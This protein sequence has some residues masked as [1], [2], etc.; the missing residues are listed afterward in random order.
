[1]F[2]DRHYAFF[3]TLNLFLQHYIIRGIG[4]M[5]TITAGNGRG[6]ISLLVR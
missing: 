3:G 1:M 4:T 5:H 2:S 6:G